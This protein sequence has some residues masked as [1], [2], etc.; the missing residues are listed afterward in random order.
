MGPRFFKRG[1][2]DC[3]FRPAAAMRASMGPRFF[4]R[5][6][7]D[8]TRYTVLTAGQLQWGHAFSSVESRAADP[9]DRKGY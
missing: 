2:P 9:L 8:G 3:R 1:E 5:G 7:L 4:K 6:E